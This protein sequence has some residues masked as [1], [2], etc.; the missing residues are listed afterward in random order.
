[1]ADGHYTYVAAFAGAAV[2][3]ETMLG[4]YK[5]SPRAGFEVAWSPGGE[6]E[7][8][9][10]RGSIEQIGALSTG[11]IAGLRVFGELSFNDLL[12]NRPEAL[13]FTPM[14]FCDR[15]MGEN[16]SE[17]GFGLS[18]ALTREDEETGLGYGI[19]VM[20]ERTASRETIGLQLNY[21]QPLFGG[22]LSGTSSVGRNGEMTV[23]A[24][25]VL[26]F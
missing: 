8:E 21:K 2:S 17:C 7:Y 5:L 14:F 15:P 23:G 19:E 24:N 9:A 11:E 10:S 18:L 26:D 6:A 20:G 3:G 22:E 4:D 1:M 16:R 12:L 25:Y 13:A